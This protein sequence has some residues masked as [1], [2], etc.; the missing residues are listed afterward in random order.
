MEILRKWFSK[1]YKHTFHQILQFLYF[2]SNHSDI[3]R[4]RVGSINVWLWNIWFSTCEILVNNQKFAKVAITYSCS[5]VPSELYT[6]IDPG[7]PLWLHLCS[8]RESLLC[9]WQ[10][11]LRYRSIMYYEIYVTWI[12]KVTTENSM[13]IF[14][15]GW[16]YFL[17]FWK[18]KILSSPTASVIYY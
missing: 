10:I 11:L 13:N 8:S 3:S 1:V 15:H 6:D 17:G 7:F 18:Y 2:F 9:Q 12:N 16:G 4:S 14:T 5:N